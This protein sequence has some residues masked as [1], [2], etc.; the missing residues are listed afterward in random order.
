MKNASEMALLAAKIWIRKELRPLFLR[1]GATL[2]KQ[3]IRVAIGLFFCLSL[4]A[5]AGLVLP[6]FD[7]VF[8]LPMYIQDDFLGSWQ[9]AAQTHAVG[10]SLSA[11]LMGLIP[12]MALLRFTMAVFTSTPLSDK[13]AKWTIAGFALLLSTAPWSI[14]WSFLGF[15]VFGLFV[16]ARWMTRVP[17]VLAQKQQTLIENHPEFL[18][19]KERARLSKLSAAIVPPSPRRL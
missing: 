2:A 16:L 10:I 18:S 15:A 12:A 8:D 4:M 19:T 1:I 7:E 11:G 6:A 3:M 14:L 5:C 17:A 9:R 13:Q